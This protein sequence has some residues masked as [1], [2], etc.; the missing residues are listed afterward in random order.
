[1]AGIRTNDKP[2][3]EEDR[4]LRASADPRPEVAQAA[5][6][7]L[8]ETFTDALEGA[9]YGGDSAKAEVIRKGVPAGDNVS[10]IYREK[11]FDGSRTYEFPL[12]LLTPGSEGRHIAYTIPVIGK[13]PT[14]HV[15][16]DYVN[17]P[18]VDYGSNI[19]W[20][21]R[22][23]EEADWDIVGRA[24]QVYE[25]GFTLKFN[26]D[27][28]HV[29]LSAAKNRNLTV[30]D[31][32]ATAGLFTK[33]LVSV[34]QLYMKRNGGGNVTSVERAGLTDIC[35]SEEGIEDVRSW[36][37][38]QVDDVTRREIYMAGEGDSEV[39]R[40][41]RTNLRPMTEFGV[42]QEYQNYY[43]DVLGGTMSGSKVEIAVGLDMKR[44]WAFVSPKRGGLQTFEDMSLHPHRRAGVYGW[45]SRG[46]SGLE[47]RACLVLQF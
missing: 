19:S 38:S 23:A 14:R 9:G 36:D 27:G 2:T 39:T 35:L 40:I 11:K 8:A 5:M 25:A 21:L 7:Q 30:L 45:Q 24:M 42:D 41:F 26:K 22:Y 6:R 17:I 20:D 44:P 16:S 43:E 4:V 10:W 29:I 32:A 34:A 28:W 47:Q 15:E 18:V 13:M 31:S 1:M 12:D 33:R 37:L 3:P 46:F